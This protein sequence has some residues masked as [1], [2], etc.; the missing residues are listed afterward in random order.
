M[1][2][3]VANHESESI[4]SDSSVGSYLTRTERPVSRQS[5]ISSYPSTYSKN[6]VSTHQSDHAGRSFNR[7]R[8]TQ[9]I[10]DICKNARK[11]YSV[12]ENA[13]GLKGLTSAELAHLDAIHKD[14][15]LQ[16][17]L[18]ATAKSPGQS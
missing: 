14:A 5:R 12:N 4:C 10:V 13:L 2:K 3:S 18:Q 6:S 15:I 9:S 8:S 7:G 1:G 11:R 16:A 17:N